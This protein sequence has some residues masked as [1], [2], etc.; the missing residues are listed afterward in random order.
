MAAMGVL[1][2]EIHNFLFM[3]IWMQVPVRSTRRKASRS[4]SQ[5]AEVSCAPGCCP[6]KSVSLQAAPVH[7]AALKALAHIGRLQVFFFL[8]QAGKPLPANEIQSALGLPGPTL[9]HHLEQLEKVG[10]IV[11]ARQ[12]RFILSSVRARTGG[13]SRSFADRL[14]L[15]LLLDP[16]P[17]ST[18][19]SRQLVAEGIGTA[20]LLA[21]VVGSGIIGRTFGWR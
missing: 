17:N 19:F 21:I 6:T 1:L 10:L 9:S 20:L 3:K 15:D 12:E 7:V 8:V 16:M 5:K 13:R 11:R 2:L 18:S 4:K 14:L